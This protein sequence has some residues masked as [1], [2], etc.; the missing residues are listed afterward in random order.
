M[1]DFSREYA[2]DKCELY[3]FALFAEAFVKKFKSRPGINQPTLVGCH[4]LQKSCMT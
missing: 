4:I 1:F 3:C 2:N